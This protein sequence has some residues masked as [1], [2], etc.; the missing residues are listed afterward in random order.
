[1]AEKAINYIKNRFFSFYKKLK[2]SIV[3]FL[4]QKIK[5]LQYFAIIK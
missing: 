1:M 5:A 2:N 3:P 4:F